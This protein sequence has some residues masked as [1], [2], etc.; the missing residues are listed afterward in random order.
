[1]DIIDV[2]KYCEDINYNL[3]EIDELIK[4]NLHKYT[5]SRLNVVDREII[6]IATYEMMKGLDPKIAI[7]EALEITKDYSDEG[8]HKQ[9]S[10]NNRVLNDIS[11]EIKK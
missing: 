6:R 3:L 7:N 8:N 5:M 1:E 11:K 4:K 2:K 9:V 10:F